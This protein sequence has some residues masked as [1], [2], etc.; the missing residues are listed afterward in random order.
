MSNPLLPNGRK[1]RLT[2]LHKKHRDPTLIPYQPV[3]RQRSNSNAPPNMA[4]LPGSNNHKMS[5]GTGGGVAGRVGF[6]KTS[7]Q[8]KKLVIKNRK[9]IHTSDLFDILYICVIS[10][11]GEREILIHT[12]TTP[13]PFQFTLYTL[14]CSLHTLNFPSIV[15]P[16]FYPLPLPPSLPHLLFLLPKPV[17]PDLPENYEAETWSKLG[18]VIVAVQ[19]Q[20][21]ISYSLEELYQAVENMCSHKMAANLYSN[22]RRE[23]DRHV[24]SL[25]PK[26]NQYPLYY[27]ITV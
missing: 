19:L 7:N 21:S 24:Q 3:K 18:E 26:F 4:H 16:L 1:R 2:P 20:R 5:A 17:K 14:C 22:L 6:N 15:S 10:H 9:G 27:H 13:P 25:V 23:G 12:P 11:S 8:G